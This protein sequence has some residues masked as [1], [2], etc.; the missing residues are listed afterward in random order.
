MS[1][2]STKP[3]IEDDAFYY[4]DGCIR[5]FISG[6]NTLSWILGIVRGADKNLL[7]QI[8]ASHEGDSNRKTQL[9]LRLM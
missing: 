7:R 4:L 2:E 6:K 8:I 3:Q 1:S 9:L 5:A